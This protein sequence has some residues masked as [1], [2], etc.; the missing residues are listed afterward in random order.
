MTHDVDALPFRADRDV[1][2]RAREVDAVDGDAVRGF[3]G[4]AIVCVVLLL[5]EC[6]SANRYE[7]RGRKA[8]APR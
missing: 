5:R 2:R 8:E 7:Q 1:V 6:C 4:G 3:T